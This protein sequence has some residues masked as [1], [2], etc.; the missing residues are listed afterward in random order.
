[1]KLELSPAMPLAFD[2]SRR[3]ALSERALEVIAPHLLTALLAEDEG[4]AATL[5]ID[6]GADWPSV[7]SHLGLPRPLDA[8]LPPDLPLHPALE[9]VMASARELTIHHGG[10]GSV[11][12]EHV[13]LALLTH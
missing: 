1:M 11:S 10:E 7:Q 4:R 9:R 3:L 12:T 8:S 5:L 6:A 13:L 2:R